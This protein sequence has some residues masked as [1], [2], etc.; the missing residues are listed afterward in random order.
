[1]RGK[2]AMFSVVFDNNSSVKCN[3]SWRINGQADRDILPLA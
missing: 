1:M 2:Q 3:V